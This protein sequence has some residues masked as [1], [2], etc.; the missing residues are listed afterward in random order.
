MSKGSLAEIGVRSN[1]PEAPRAA[2]TLKSSS[3]SERLFFSDSN[4]HEPVGLER[5]PSSGPQEIPRDYQ[6][7]HP[8]E[9]DAHLVEVTSPDPAPEV[10]TAATYSEG[11]RNPRPP[12]ETDSKDDGGGVHDW[13]KAVAG[14]EDAFDRLFSSIVFVDEPF[15]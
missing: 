6:E 7:D 15:E 4:D 14:D 13:Y 10:E 2:S 5:S 11:P 12:T 9:F 3:S 8:V 1:G